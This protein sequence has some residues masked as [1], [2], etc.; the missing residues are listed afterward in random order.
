MHYLAHKSINESCLV[1]YRIAGRLDD[2]ASLDVSD[3]QILAFRVYG[4][5]VQV[6][7][8]GVEG[9]N[10]SAVVLRAGGP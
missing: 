9:S 8:S 1:T 4:I 2:S 5:D 6:V 10:A 7:G 3:E